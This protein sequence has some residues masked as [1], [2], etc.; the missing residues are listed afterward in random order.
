MSE[1]NSSMPELNS[2]M[3]EF[4]SSNKDI[5][6]FIIENIDYSAYAKEFIEDDKEYYEIIKSYTS[7][8]T[9]ILSIQIDG[10]ICSI[11]DYNKDGS[12]TEFIRNDIAYDDCKEFKS[13]VEWVSDY[14]GKILTAQSILNNVYIG[15]GNI[16]LWKVLVIAKEEDDENNSILS[17]IS[18]TGKCIAPMIVI[19]IW[20]CMIIFMVA[21]FLTIIVDVSIYDGG[22]V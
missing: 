11:S 7:E 17:N 20:L 2:S 5:Y 13:I 10:N 18:D 3:S 8:Y 12:V 21:S 19:G 14:Y 16:P 1:F 22:V 15:E 4:N 9:V 6:K